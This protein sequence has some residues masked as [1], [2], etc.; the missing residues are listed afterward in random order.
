[1]GNPL[2]FM[3]KRES[4]PSPSK[5]PVRVLLVEDDEENLDTVRQALDSYKRVSFIVEAVASTAELR[6]ELARLAIRDELTGLYSRWFIV[7]SLAAES[8]RV[9][10]Y[11]RDLSCVMVDVDDFRLINEAHGAEVGDEALKRVAALIG[12]SV[13][14]E[15]IVAR[16][17]EDRFGILLLETPLNDAMTAAERIRFELAS[18]PV[19]IGQRS[20]TITVSIGVCAIGPQQ[21]DD[22]PDAVFDRAAEA[23]RQAKDAGKNRVF[24]H[25][26]TAEGEGP[27]DGEGRAV[28]LGQQSDTGA[29]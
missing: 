24:A 19:V 9:R 29:A 13:R 21:H 16:F 17:G 11:G 23:L 18:Q 3:K 28:D 7:E 5:E 27:D 6:T 15:D 10:R 2:S 12:N 1:M 14:D 8:R 20:L 25:R 26:H 4:K 22:S